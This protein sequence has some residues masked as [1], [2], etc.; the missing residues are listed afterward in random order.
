MVIRAVIFD[1]FGTI[2]PAGRSASKAVL[3]EMAERLTADSYEFATAWDAVQEE[4]QVTGAGTLEEDIYHALR[5][6]NQFTHRDQV[7]AAVT[8]MAAYEKSLF[9]PRLAALETLEALR[10]RNTRVGVVANATPRLATLWRQTEC[11][12]L[13]NASIF[14]YEV[15]ERMPSRRIFEVTAER[16][17]VASADSLFV[18][19][20][21]R[22]ALRASRLEGMTPLMFVHDDMPVA[23]STPEG[24]EPIG[25]PEAQSLVEVLDYAA[26]VLETESR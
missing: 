21:D 5:Y 18:S 2:I 6:L 16:L 11:G 3:A 26:G 24:F 20:G 17:G 10:G 7:Y 19:D 23:D 4:R 15:G 12:R 13:A 25:W 14:S 9:E 22:Y 8:L 1:L